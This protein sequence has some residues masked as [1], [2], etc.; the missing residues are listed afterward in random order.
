MA[1]ITTQVCFI[2]QKYS[3]IMHCTPNIQGIIQD[4]MHIKGIDNDKLNSLG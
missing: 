4:V 2:V 3:G 1:H